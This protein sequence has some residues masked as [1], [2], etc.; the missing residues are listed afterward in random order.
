MS[1]LNQVTHLTE[2]PRRDVPV[3]GQD[4]VKTASVSVLSVN[5]NGIFATKFESDSPVYGV[6]G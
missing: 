3:C 1:N 4:F 6:R 5:V 2:V